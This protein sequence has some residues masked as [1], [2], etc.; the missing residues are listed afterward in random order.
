MHCDASKHGVG[1]PGLQTMAS[2]FAVAIGLVS[3]LAAACLSPSTALAQAWP[4]RPI[5]L[6]LAYPP[7]GGTDN[8][9]RMLAKFWSEQMGVPVVV[10]NR[11]GAGGR[12]GTQSVARAAPDGYTVLF[13]TGAELTMAPATV[14]KMPYDPERDFDPVTQIGGGPY[15]LIASKS[16]PPNNV[17]ELVAYEKQNPGK[18]NYSSGGM[19]A[20]THLI[21]LQ[22]NDRTGINTL[23]VPYRGSGPSLVGL[24]GGEVQYTFNT[25][26]S[27]LE[28][29]QGGK[30]KIL[31]VASPARLSKLPDVPTIAESGYPGF[32]G[33]SWYGLMVP[34]GTPAAATERLRAETIKFL[35]DEKSRAAL[36]GVYIRPIGS[37]AEELKKLISSEIARYKQ[38]MTK[39]KLAPE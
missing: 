19:Y 23:H 36:E 11:G 24:M 4:S 15:L 21:G 27:S 9:A 3:A 10:D 26:S 17:Q 14:A 34:A 2:R 6:V 30:V 33:G 25:P 20:A 32:A 13:G 28:L 16:F 7:G 35:N 38:L 37:S 12:I 18:V 39:L 29:V 31:A 5:T 22:F 1:K 8:V